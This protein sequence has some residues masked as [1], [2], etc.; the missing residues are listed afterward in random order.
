MAVRC[1]IDPRQ[2]TKFERSA[3]RVD[4]KTL[5]RLSEGYNRHRDYLIR[6]KTPPLDILDPMTTAFRYFILALNGDSLPFQKDEELQHALNTSR[7]PIFFALSRAD[8][9]RLLVHLTCRGYTYIDA[10]GGY[11]L[12]KRWDAQEYKQLVQLRISVER[13]CVEWNFD[14][15]RRDLEQPTILDNMRK[16]LRSLRPMISELSD[17]RLEVEELVDRMHRFYAA[18]PEVHIEKAGRSGK[19]REELSGK[20]KSVARLAH[21]YLEVRLSAAGG[22]W[23]RV[24]KDLVAE[25]R[26]MLEDH[27]HFIERAEAAATLRE[28]CDLHYSHSATMLERVDA[29]FG[30]LVRQGPALA[31]SPLFGVEGSE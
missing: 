10:T 5:Q 2:L 12:L 6:M 29:Y 11:Y 28:L 21:D 25:G 16:Q 24:A 9:A 7:E 17:S 23:K 18:E 19:L 3:T 20:L 1:R 8:V 30:L 14:P 27:E 4:G 31:K 26:T 22:N 15:E 13:I